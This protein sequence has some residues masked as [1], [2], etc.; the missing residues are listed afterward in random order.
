[1]NAIESHSLR[2]VYPAPAGTL[3]LLAAICGSAGIAGAIAFHAAPETPWIGKA[4]F[5]IGLLA[6]GWDAAVDFW[7][8]LTTD[9]GA[10]FDR[11]VHIDGSK[12][13]P[14]VTWGTNPGQGAPLNSAVPN[15]ADFA[16]RL[17]QL[18]SPKHVDTLRFRLKN[19]AL[20]GVIVDQATSSVGAQWQTLMHEVAGT[21]A[22]QFGRANL[23]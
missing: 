8:S 13:S 22:P 16:D 15:P 11:T 10:T 20:N 19:T 2:K 4:L 12:L 14:W 21:S 1:M 3:S 7:R 17:I 23:T 5:L 18:F 6:G 9:A